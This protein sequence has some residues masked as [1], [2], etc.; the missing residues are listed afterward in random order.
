MQEELL[1]YPGLG[2]GF[3]VGG[4]SSVNKMLKFYVK[5]FKSLY[6]LNPQMDL[7][8]FGMIIDVRPKFY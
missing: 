5:V 3:E 6:F 8:I 7:F 2:V 1:H 4:S